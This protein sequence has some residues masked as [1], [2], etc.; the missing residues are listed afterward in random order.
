M[1]FVDWYSNENR[2]KGIGK[3]TPAQKHA[4]ENIAILQ[5]RKEVYEAAKAKHP[6]RWKGRNTRKWDVVKQTKLNHVTMKDIE[7]ELKKVA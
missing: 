4:G 6:E 1:G 7:K 3:V 2:H 5:K